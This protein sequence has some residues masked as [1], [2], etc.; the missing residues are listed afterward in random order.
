[1]SSLYADAWQ[2]AILREHQAIEEAGTWSI[3]NIT[4]PPKG[5]KPVGSQWVFKVKHYADGSDERHKARIVAKGYSQ[6][7][8]LHYDETCTPVTWYD[9]LRLVFALALYLG[10]HMEQL[11]IKSAFL[12][13]ELKEEIWMIPAPGIGLDGKILCLHK[14]LYGLK[15]VRL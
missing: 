6:Q 12:N 8:G 7:E 9:S 11:D 13:G 10:L 15:Q 1:M 4:D 5:R 14:A 3:Y 2:Q